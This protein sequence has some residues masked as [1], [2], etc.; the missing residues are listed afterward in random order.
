MSVNKYDKIEKPGP[1]PVPSSSSPRPLSVKVPVPQ[2]YIEPPKELLALGFIGT[3]VFCIIDAGKDN[4]TE[5]NAW[6]LNFTDEP[7]TLN[8]VQGA[9]AIARVEAVLTPRLGFQSLKDRILA[10]RTPL[11]IE[12]VS[13]IIPELLRTYQTFQ[14]LLCEHRSV[15]C[16][17]HGDPLVTI[18]VHPFQGQL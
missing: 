18:G 3:N 12:K 8:C 17:F 15:L 5:F 7:G 13:A 2:R 14:N 11:S 16:R 10:N 6:F 1:I 4:G 9:L